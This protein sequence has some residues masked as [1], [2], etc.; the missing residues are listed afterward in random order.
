MGQQDG[1]EQVAPVAVQLERVVPDGRAPVEALLDDPVALAVV[2]SIAAGVASVV[3][4]L[5]SAQPMA[6]L[7]IV[8]GGAAS[9]VV[10]RAVEEAA[11]IRLVAGPAEAT[12]LGNALLQGIA[13]GRFETLGAARA[14]AAADAPDA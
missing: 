3:G 9:P 13:L 4:E 5:R 2:R 6:E 10:R 11:G 1:E 12:G 14:W 8:G 7:A